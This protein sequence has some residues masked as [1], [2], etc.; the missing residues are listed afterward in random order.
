M[1]MGLNSELFVTRNML[2]N[3]LFLKKKLSFGYNIPVFRVRSCT[4]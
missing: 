4:P 3:S 2:D 1:F